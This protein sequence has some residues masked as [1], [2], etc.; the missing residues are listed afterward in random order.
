MSK[1][2]TDIYESFTKGE[3]PDVVMQEY[4]E[5]EGNRY[6]VSTV[7]TFDKGWETMVFAVKPD[8]TNDWTDLYSARYPDR[9]AAEAGHKTVIDGFATLT[10]RNEWAE[11]SEAADTWDDWKK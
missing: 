5:R 7:D 9:A 10:L 1:T 8:G 11:D 4:I 3:K 2:F 6:W